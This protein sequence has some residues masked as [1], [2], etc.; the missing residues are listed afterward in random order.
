MDSHDI[1]KTLNGLA[2]TV[3]PTLIVGI[4]GT[5]A[6]ALQQARLRF[7][8]FMGRSCSWVA[9]RAFDTAPQENRT[10]APLVEN[11]EFIYLGGFDAQSVIHD[12]IGGRLPHYSEWLPPWLTFQQVASG[13]GGIRPIG[14]LCYFYQHELVK[15]AADLALKSI[16]DKSAATQHLQEAG[17]RV[18]LEAGIDI[19]IVGSLCGGTGSGIF[20]DLAYDLRRWAKQHTNKE[21]KVIGHLV[22]PEAFRNLPVAMRSLEANCYAALQE[23]DHFMNASRERAWRVEYE[24]QHVEVDQGAPFSTCYLLSGLQKGGG[25]EDIDGLTSMIGEALFLLTATEMGQEAEK[26]ATN[27]SQQQRITIDERHRACCYSSYGL[28]GIEIPSELLGHSLGASLAQDMKHR[29][30]EPGPRQDEDVDRRAEA[31][32]AVLGLTSENVDAL[33]PALDLDTSSVQFLIDNGQEGT[34][35]VSLP[36]LLSQA[37]ASLRNRAEQ[38]AS[39]QPCNPE[40]LRN[41]LR[42]GLLEILPAPSGFDRSLRFLEGVLNRLRTLQQTLAARAEQA[43]QTAAPHRA[44]AESVER[45]NVRDIKKYEA[46]LHPWKVVMSE[47]AAERVRRTQSQQLGGHIALVDSV[48]DKMRRVQAMFA[49]LRLEDP[50]EEG[51]YYRVHRSRIGVCPLAWFIDLLE[52]HRQRMIEDILKGLAEQFETWSLIGAGELSGRIYDICTRAI[53]LHFDREAGMTCDHLLADCYGYPSAHYTEIVNTFASRARASWEMHETYPLRNNVLEM[54]YIAAPSNS[55]ISATLNGTQRMKAV[56]R[57]WPWYVPIFRSEHGFSLIGLKRLGDYRS[58]FTEAVE[59]Q[60]RYDL[61]LFLDRNWVS[62]L[63]FPDDNLEELAI[64]RW[65]SLAECAGV[66]NRGNECYTFS[67]NGMPPV[68]LKW[69]R[70]DSFKMFRED[71]AMVAAA[72]TA[73]QVSGVLS[74]REGLEKCLERLTTKLAQ[75]RACAVGGNGYAEQ[76]ASREVHQIHQEIRAI[77]DV[78]RG[79]GARL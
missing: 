34:A 65:F 18:D 67:A 27:T 78:M 62:D 46:E 11:T 57:S 72:R 31:L 73:V 37:R 60:Q 56:E 7:H 6:A 28:L 40:Q 39:R 49:N 5:G 25:I 8:Q 77:H 52:P 10:P 45:D 54:A 21:V 13:A 51:H 30:M 36:E 33:V 41:T 63:P 9:L 29:L 19:H 48:V 68:P 26:G 55:R 16:L 12:V 20:L 47:D 71:P 4:G 59:V 50:I 38:N 53:R 32:P 14:R 24:P 76:P 69:Y 75:A 74:N 44:A 1:S 17:V 66:L 43:R 64:L 42:D 2:H 61:H 3:R 15:N 35:R 79:P 58:S 22:L 23:L 70:S